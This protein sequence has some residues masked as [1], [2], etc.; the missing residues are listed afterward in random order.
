MIKHILLA[1]MMIMGI[2]VHANGGDTPDICSAVANYAVIATQIRFQD[3]TF[4]DKYN[5]K[6]LR[7]HRDLVDY[8]VIQVTDLGNCEE[9]GTNLK[10]S[11]CRVAGG[12]PEVY[13]YE[14]GHKES[15][16]V[17][18]IAGVIVT[19]NRGSCWVDELTHK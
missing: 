2:A 3:G 16:V 13:Q 19:F 11:W 5:P 8:P 7:F 14:F 9:N 6:S 15:G 1:T 4:S 12:S 10:E 17:T 18:P